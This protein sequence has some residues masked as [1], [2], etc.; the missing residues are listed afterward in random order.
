MDIVGYVD[1]LAAAPGD[2]IS[3]HVSSKDASFTTS[4]ARILHGD[5]HPEGPGWKMT[6]ID[7]D[8]AGTYP[9]RVQPLNAGSYVR[10]EDVSA[11]WGP[12][13]FR[14]R[15]WIYPTHLEKDPSR[16]VRDAGDKAE[17]RWSLSMPIDP[18]NEQT[19]AS[20]AVSDQHGWW[21]RMSPAGV[22]SLTAAVN[23]QA[24]TLTASSAVLPHVW[25]EIEISASA[26]DAALG[27][28]IVPKVPHPQ[29]S[30]APMNATMQDTYLP[31]VPVEGTADLIFGA[32]ADPAS[33][34]VRAPF[35]GKISDPVLLDD[36]G[37]E[38][39]HWD[40]SQ[41]LDTRT[42][43]DTG[44]RRLHAQTVNF[45]A[46]GV[47]GP[48]WT[49]GTESFHDAPDQYNAVHLHDD[50]LDDA[51]WDP[52]LTWTV[53]HNLQSGTYVFI[54]TGDSGAVDHIPFV[55]LPPKDRPTS[56]VLLVLP[57]FSYLAYANEHSLWAR[58]EQAED[59]YLLANRLNGLYDRHLNDP[60]G[61]GVAYSSWRRPLMNMRPHYYWMALRGG[62]G[63][64]HQFSADLHLVDWLQ[65]AEITVDVI[66]DAEF[67]RAGAAA[68]AKYR[69]VVTGTHAEYWSRRMLDGLETYLADGGRVMYM[70]GN[71]LYWVTGLDPAE[72]HTVEVRRSLGMS[73]GWYARPGEGILS[74]TGESGG[75]WRQHGL[76]P[77]KYVGVGTAAFLAEAAEG[78]GGP[79]TF[80]EGS[81][82]P[83]AAFLM[84]GVVDRTLLGDFPNL[85]N[86]WGPVGYEADRIDF[87]LGT[88]RHAILI[89]SAN[90]DTTDVLIACFEETLSANPRADVAFYETANGGAVFATGSISWAGSLH[91]HGYDNDVARLTRNV[92]NRFRDPDPFAPP[93]LI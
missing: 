51:R 38:L 40:M 52:C 9:G 34:G 93:D 24:T 84:E 65:E 62:K 43:V 88:P 68:L 71:G 61:D 20:W 45:P 70:S 46:R 73:G 66:T 7:A 10:V 54:V 33:E 13:G 81:R 87:H 55:V 15:V 36:T 32:E 35:N 25:Y 22:L 69:V 11:A 3:L 53:P 72:G 1:P 47:T 63:G 74:T 82:N 44:T 16:P 80:Q 59:E 31:A 19:V 12:G 60:N 48:T 89:A 50:D 29:A 17:R 78:R 86:G 92:L 14:L 67:D 85:V 91:Y 27:L 4:V 21:L 75:A 90:P 23:G 58:S 6:A 8:A 42:V 57:T 56:D 83:R 37:A 39:A 26:S 79:F 30:W 49:E 41:M 28:N 18:V 77:Q 76:A 64:V 5:P 2:Q